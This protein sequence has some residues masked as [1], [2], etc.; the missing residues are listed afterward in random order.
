[1]KR[2]SS[3]TNAISWV[4]SSERLMILCLGTSGVSE[5]RQPTMPVILLLFSKGSMGFAAV[6]W[7]RKTQ[8]A[9]SGL[10]LTNET[11]SLHMDSWYHV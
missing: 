8:I 7:P 11:Q 6:L 5:Q 4:G 2:L 1:M 3:D 9:G 10:V